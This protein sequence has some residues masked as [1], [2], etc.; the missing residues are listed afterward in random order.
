M[1][2]WKTNK[3][4]KAIFIRNM[5]QV[6]KIRNNKGDALTEHENVMDC[7][8]TLWTTPCEQINNN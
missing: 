1:A 6:I 7:K 5:T 8:E 3:I 4:D 2:L